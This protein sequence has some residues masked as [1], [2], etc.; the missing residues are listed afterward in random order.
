M[1]GESNMSAVDRQPYPVPWH[2]F[3]MFM[4]CFGNTKIMP[5]DIDFIVERKGNFLV[6]ELKVENKQI[7]YGQELMLMNL[8]KIPKFTVVLAYHKPRSKCSLCGAIHDKPEFTSIR[9]YPSL[10]VVPITN[11]GLKNIVSEWYSKI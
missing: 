3:D 10:K 7:F 4:G 9:I 11:E 5:T 2:D 8:S 6:M 1:L